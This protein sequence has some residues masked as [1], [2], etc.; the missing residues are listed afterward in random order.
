[1]KWLY[2]I[3]RNCF[4]YEAEKGVEKYEIISRIIYI[5]QKIRRL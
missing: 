5:K 4:F 1:M 2:V 3:F